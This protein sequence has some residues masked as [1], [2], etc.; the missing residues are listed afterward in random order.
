MGAPGVIIP[1]E[2]QQGGNTETGTAYVFTE[3]GG[4]W[5]G[6]DAPAAALTDGIVGDKLGI[7][8]ALGGEEH[9]IHRRA[10][11]SP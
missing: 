1:G 9:S 4:G 5:T 6:S 8:V 3:P 10:M 2:P 7:S 11:R